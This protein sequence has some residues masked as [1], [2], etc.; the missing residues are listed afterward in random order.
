VRVRVCICESRYE[1]GMHTKCC[2]KL[3]PFGSPSAS[4]IPSLNGLAL[5][6]VG[7][8]QTALVADNGLHPLSR[9][10]F[11]KWGPL[12]LRTPVD[13]H[14]CLIENSWAIDALSALMWGPLDLRTPVDLHICLIEKSWAIDALSALMWGPLDL[15]TPVDLHICLIE[16]S[17][18]IDAPSALMWGPLDLRTPVNLHMC[19]NLHICLKANLWAI[20]ALSALMWK[21]NAAAAVSSLIMRSSKSCCANFTWCWNLTLSVVRLFCTFHLLRSGHAIKFLEARDNWWIHQ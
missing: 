12:D 11:W 15:R 5:P 21:G 19:Y 20:D 16:N 4:C 8:A 6:A 3:T 13:L 2:I 10:R 7:I 14:I 18:A 17:W 9:A 1:K